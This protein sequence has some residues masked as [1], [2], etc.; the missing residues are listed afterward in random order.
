LFPGNESFVGP[1]TATAHSTSPGLGQIDRWCEQKNGAHFRLAPLSQGR[2]WKWTPLSSDFRGQGPDRPATGQTA[3]GLTCL[4]LSRLH[5]N[6]DEPLA[7]C[8]G[9]LV[10]ESGAPKSV[11][12]S[13]GVR[14]VRKS[15]ALLSGRLGLA[16]GK[17][18]RPTM[19]C[20]HHFSKCERGE[21]NANL[22][23]G[24]WSD[25]GSHL[26]A[27]LRV[28]LFAPLSLRVA[29]NKVMRGVAKPRRGRTPGACPNFCVNGLEF[30]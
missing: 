14:T 21:N 26:G 5:A 15:G 10:P 24:R 9:G 22:G 1:G 11:W 29:A 12:R 20:S 3:V 27:Q 23:A 28:A 25:W 4:S 8:W 18:L 17:L 30:S 16:P 7:M 2:D 6:A 19:A 13:K